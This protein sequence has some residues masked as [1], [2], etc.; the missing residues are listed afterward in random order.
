MQHVKVLPVGLSAC[1]EC[2]HF[3]ELPVVS[4]FF[5]PSS[6]LFYEKQGYY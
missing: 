3:E 6:A 1:L 5:Y 2:I 4:V